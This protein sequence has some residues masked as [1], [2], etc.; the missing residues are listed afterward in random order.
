MGVE[1]NHALGARDGGEEREVGGDARNE[2][3]VDH[4]QVYHTQNRLRVWVA[5]FCECR[6]GA[7]GNQVDG[8]FVQVDDISQHVAMQQPPVR[9]GRQ[10]REPRH[11]LGTVRIRIRVRWLWP[12]I[13]TSAQEPTSAINAVVF[14]TRWP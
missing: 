4:V 2:L 7:V 6:I 3:H 12:R 8:D 11:R 14:L 10:W 13:Q 9:Y 1:V 5:T